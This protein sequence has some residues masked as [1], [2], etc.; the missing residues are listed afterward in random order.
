MPLKI[1]ATRPLFAVVGAGD[2]A[3]E[4]ART[5]ATDVQTRFA[6]VEIEPKALRDQARTVVIARVD[7]LAKDAKEA[8]AKLEARVAGLQADAKTLPGK[9]ESFTNETV[10]ELNETYGDLAARGRDLVN[11]IRKQQATQD[12]KAAGKSTVAKAKTTKTQATKSA[13][14]SSTAAKKTAKTA[15]A[16]AKKTG[17][18]AKSSAKATG[19][20]AAKTASA[21]T[22]AVTDGA[23]KVGN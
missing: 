3:V 22:Q 14:A 6:K 12:A 5:Y 21:G 4:F 7:E 11:R 8:Q 15:T 10:A 16:T 13:T 17:A 9:V 19:T 2:L 1:D 23:S 18:T 20:S